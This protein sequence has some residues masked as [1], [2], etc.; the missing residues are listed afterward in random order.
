MKQIFIDIQNRLK[1]RA[2]SLQYI[3]K[4]WGQLNMPQPPV[5]WPCCLLDIEDIQFSELSGTMRLATAT[6]SLVLADQHSTRS[7]GDA[8]HREDA[9]SIL[10]T[11]EEVIEALEGYRVPETTQGLTRTQL[12]KSYTDKSYDVYALGYTTAW[13]S[14]IEEEGQKQSV[15]V[16]IEVEA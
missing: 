1:D 13:V 5:K 11:I 16:K 2:P 9:Y 10:D 6:L 3:D 8:Q 4:N 12:R 14:H 7:S 15:T